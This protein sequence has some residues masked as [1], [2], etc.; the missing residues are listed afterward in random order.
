MCKVT[1]KSQ[2]KRTKGSYPVYF[3]LIINIQQGMIA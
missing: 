3:Y 1:E 2:G